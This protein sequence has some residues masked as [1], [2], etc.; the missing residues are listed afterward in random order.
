MKPLKQRVQLP[1]TQSLA[2]IIGSVLFITAPSYAGL[3][4]YLKRQQQMRT[5]PQYIIRSIVQTGPQ[6]GALKTDVLAEILGLSA[7]RPSHLLRFDLERAK[8]QLLNFPVIARAEIKLIKPSTIY[9]DYTVR[10]PIAWIEDF[11][12]MVID[13]EGYPFPLAPFFTPKNLPALYFGAAP[14]GTFSIDSDRPVIQWGEPIGGKHF[15][16]AQQILSIVTDSKVEDLFNVKRIDVSNAFAESYGTRE[17]VLMTEDTVLHP[18]RGK[19]TP[20]IFPR[21]LRLSTKNFAQELGNYLQLRHQL[22]EEE[23]KRLV[24]SENLLESTRFKERVLDFRIQQLAFVEE[25]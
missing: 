17:I 5:D 8:Q 13:K 10:Q 9:I 3:K 24:K 15:E 21:V 7:D 14:F 22:L 4:Y 18:V 23:R 19:P 12:N 16:I 1:L 6:K 20:F 2:W 25:L 11:E